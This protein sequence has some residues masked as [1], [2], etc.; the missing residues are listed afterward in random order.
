MTRDRLSLTVSAPAEA[1]S[2]AAEI[3]LPGIHSAGRSPS[4]PGHSPVKPLTT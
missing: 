2:R 1:S 4:S 3:E